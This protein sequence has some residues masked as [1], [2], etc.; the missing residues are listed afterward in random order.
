M[1]VPDF[2][3]EKRNVLL[4]NNVSKTSYNCFAHRPYPVLEN[5]AV[6]VITPSSIENELT[7]FHDIKKSL[8]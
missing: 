1:P 2:A 4:E 8:I 3:T 7:C 5:S 6:W